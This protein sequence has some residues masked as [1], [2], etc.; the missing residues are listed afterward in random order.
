MS[1]FEILILAAGK[2]SRMKTIK[3]K[4]FNKIKGI[5]IIDLVIRK[6]LSLKASKV[7]VILNKDYRKIKKDYPNV[8]FFYQ[9]RPLGTGHAVQ[10]FLKKRKI[11]KDLIIMM[12]D[13]PLI[14]T[15]SIKKIA[16]DLKKKCNYILGAKVKNNS[17]H[18][19]LKFEGK[20]VTRIIEFNFLKKFEKKNSICNTGIFA[21]KK[22]N[23]ELIKKIK[24]NPVKK[25]Y[26]LTD[27]VNIFYKTK[28]CLKVILTSPGIKSFG[29]NNQNELR[30]LQ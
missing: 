3:P 14:N 29:I 18:G 21:I 25:E 12:G 1:K 9:S 23:L 2:G 10:T 26:L 17:S 8:N 22:E 5:R 7:N 4:L 16:K 6:A 27:L 28:I 13:A 19:V 30:K 11:N 15:L 24:K 20:Q